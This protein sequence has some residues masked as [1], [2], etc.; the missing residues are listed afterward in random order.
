[1][2]EFT[3][4]QINKIAI[5]IET[6]NGCGYQILATKEDKKLALTMLAKLQGGLKVSKPIKPIE[7]TEI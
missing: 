5:L 6:E 3:T 1:M 7:I 2:N 4:D